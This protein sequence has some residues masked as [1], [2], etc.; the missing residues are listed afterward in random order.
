MRPAPA[1]LG[2]PAGGGS[3]QAHGAENKNGL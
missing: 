3:G 1:G 2:L